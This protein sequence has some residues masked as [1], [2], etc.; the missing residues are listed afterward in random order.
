MIEFL[1]LIFG[2]S[3]FFVFWLAFCFFAVD[4]IIRTN[5]MRK[6]EKHFRDT[7]RYRNEFR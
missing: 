5:R 3:A 6:A 4:W 7:E 1:L 2:L